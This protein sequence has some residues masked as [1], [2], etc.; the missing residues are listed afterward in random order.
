[1]NTNGAAPDIAE[2]TNIRTFA[3]FASKWIIE[4]FIVLL[5]G[6]YLCSSVYAPEVFGHLAI[7]RWINAQLKAPAVDLWTV[8]GQG[9]DIRSG[10][11]LFES[12]V[13]FCETAAG[14]QGLLILKLLLFTAF[15]AVC[16]RAFS[17]RS[18]N[19]FFGVS[20]AIVVSCGVL[21][22]MCLTA[23]LAGCVFFC[24]SLEIFYRAR[25]KRLK[26]KNYLLLALF[27]CFYT[28]IHT[29]AVGA[30]LVMLCLGA[31]GERTSEYAADGRSSGCAL[32]L[33]VFAL[34]QLITPYAGRQTLTA[35]LSFTSSLSMEGSLPSSAAT[36][37]YYPAAFMAILWMLIAYFWHCHPENMRSREFVV[38][39]L[40]SL[41]G[42]AWKEYIPYALIFSGFVVSSLWGR[43][44]G[45]GF[46]NLGTA[47]AKLKTQLERLPATGILWVIFC[48]IFINVY[49]L[50]K[51]PVAT[52]FLPQR[53][54]D[55]L[56]EKRLPFPV[57]HEAAIGPYLVYRFT[58]AAGYPR[59]QALWTPQVLAVNPDLSRI[60]TSIR[61]IQGEWQKAFE[62]FNPGTVLCRRQSALYELLLR[63][64]SWKLVFKEGRPAHADQARHQARHLTV[65]WAVFSRQNVE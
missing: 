12:I 57:L 45:Q 30:L 53:E 2:E 52:A 36:V 58:D 64:S 9:Q 51:Q 41:L 24:L 50:I 19:R 25:C 48:L 35:L 20:S 56:L 21:L 46:G 59:E 55:F 34:T 47:L 4:L 17:V 11:W 39:M 63:D 28:N 1:M 42:L 5:L 10:V 32:F 7:G 49:A 6:S 26:A 22:G 18:A 38:L 65:S 3:H 54:V 16:A 13:S 29:S 14:E 31:C 44:G 33:A 15:V 62:L 61:S 40:L 60:E 23:Q 27:G 37:F 8:A 43:A